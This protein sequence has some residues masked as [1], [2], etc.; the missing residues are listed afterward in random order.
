MGQI[1]N[2]A[3]PSDIV[4]VSGAYNTVTE[5]VRSGV[6]QPTGVPGSYI[7]R[8]ASPGTTMAG[9]PNPSPTVTS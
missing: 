2:A 9:G 1:I 7:V 4:E 6:L 3:S 8:D 5:F